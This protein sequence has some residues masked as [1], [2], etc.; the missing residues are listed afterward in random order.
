MKN[1][2]KILALLLVIALTATI[3]LSATLAY[4]TDEE[5]AVNVM[6]MGNIDIEQ[7]EHDRNGEDF[8]QGQILLPIVGNTT[9]KDANGYPLPDNYIDKIV[10]V[11]NVGGNDAYIRTFI[12]IPNYTY[13]G[14]A[15]NDASANVLHWNGYSEGDAAPSYPTATWLPA[16]QMGVDNHWSWGK[17]ASAPV[18]PG[19]G[20]DWNTFETTIDGQAYTVYV[21]T[22]TEKVA[23]GEITAPNMT[24]VYLD[25]MVDYDHDTGN[26]TINGNV[27][28]GFD[29]TV[30]VLVATQAVQYDTGWGDAWTALNTAF[31]IPSSD[32]NHPWTDNYKLPAV[33]DNADGLVAALEESRDVILEDDVKI[34]PAGMSNAYGTTGI[35]VKNGQTID[36]CGNT[37]DIQG[38]G[39]TWDSGISTTGGTIK[40]ITITGSFRGVFINHN[41]THSERVI[42]ENVIIDGTT[43]T[44]SCD[45]GTNQGLTATNS[46]FNGWTSYAAT[47]GDAKFVGCSFGEGNGYAYFR[48]YAPTEFVN[49][50]FEAGYEMDARAAVT[51]ENC[52]LGGVLI[53]ADNVATL[54]TSNTANATV[55]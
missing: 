7:R 30:E 41:S 22:H 52:T 18:W 47:L 55:K 4:L 35:N 19:N 28:E 12:A 29:G 3:T 17:D 44:I 45:Q 15:D 9:Q 38:A 16:E 11:K 8:E 53:T 49:C 10:S 43:Y 54:V 42:L 14:Q 32:A 26:Y 25:S 5:E 31:G 51:F 13:E 23:P 27:I 39:G 6:V 20:G 34:D 1:A 46:T 40:N 33:V 2:K 50:A 37:L 48:P 21:V 24:G 36:G